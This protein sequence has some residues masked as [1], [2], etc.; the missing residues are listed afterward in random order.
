MKNKGSA[1]E[2]LIWQA[3]ELYPIE[4]LG[5]FLSDK[6][7][8]VRYAAARRLQLFGGEHAFSLALTLVKS[9]K[10]SD[11]AIGVFILGQLDTPRFSFKE[12]SIPIIISVLKND[13]S[14]EV[15]S[16]AIISLGHLYAESAINVIAKYASHRDEKIR[17]SVAS[18]LS[19]FS[20]SKKAKKFLNAL[21]KDDSEMVR[22][23]A[24]E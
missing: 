2:T 5:Q 7:R 19:R 13:D 10:Y 3:I 1:L 16:E 6:N 9:K 8:K 15:K 24:S 20:T 14:D 17:A 11:R 23:W 18:V 21:R 12:R 4:N 22:Y